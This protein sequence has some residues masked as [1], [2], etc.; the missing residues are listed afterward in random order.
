MV[1]HK[2]MCKIDIQHLY[3]RDGVYY[4]VRRIPKDIQE[5]YSSSRVVI[6]LKTHIR[7][8]ALRLSRSFAQ[9]IQMGINN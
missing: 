6:C 2:M 9:Y 4:F 8:K 1:M 5:R 3:I 7:D